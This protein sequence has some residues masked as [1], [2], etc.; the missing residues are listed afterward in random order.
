MSALEVTRRHP[1][2]LPPDGCRPPGA[3][4]WIDAVDNP[5]LHGL[6]AP[7]TDEVSAEALDVVEGELPQG[8]YGAYFRNGPNNRFPPKGRYHWFD[9]DG[10]LHGLTLGDGRASYRN[11]WV[12]TKGF[13]L[14]RKRGRPLWTGLLER[15]M[16]DNPDGPA[17]NTANTSLVFHDRRLLALQEQGEPYEIAVP[18]LS[19][20]GPYTFRRRLHH[21]FTAHPKVDPKTGEMFT[22]GYSSVAKPH[23]QYSAISADGALSHTTAIELPIGVMMHDFAITERYAVFMNHPYT[24]DIR[25]MLR[26]EPIGAFEPERGS[27]LGLLPR[28]A[29]G[30]V[31]RWFAIPPCFVYHTVNAWDDGDVVVLE[32]CHRRSIRFDTDGEGTNQ[33]GDSPVLLRWRIDL[34]SGLVRE[35]QLDDQSADLPRIHEGYTGRRARF[36]YAARFRRDI[37]LP[38]ASGLIKYDLVRATSQVHEYG[39]NRNGGEAVFVPRPGSRDEDDGYLLSLV[40]DEVEARSELLVIDARDFTGEP[41]AR[42]LLPQRVPYGFHGLWL[43]RERLERPA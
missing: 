9:G 21:A 25:R 13:E 29:S 18:D 43:S 10:M 1:A 2:T 30:G 15:P 32:V 23:L 14:E 12:R 35:E 16:F 20:R 41:L 31:I 39:P 42:V 40:H 26:G 38:L 37:G 8:L 5:Y 19:T 7:V 6:F 36:A 3:P 24:Y 28:R 27:F 4:A 22:F 11:R 17:K 33:M 34:R